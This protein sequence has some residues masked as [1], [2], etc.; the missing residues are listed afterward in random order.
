[1]GVLTFFKLYKW[2]HI[3]QSITYN[4]TVIN[5]LSNNKNK[6]YTRF[7]LFPKQ[8]PLEFSMMIKF[9][10][11]FMFFALNLTHFN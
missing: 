4:M 1:M 8:L 3:T 7:R 6:I 5:H 10:N 2:F 9:W 11:I